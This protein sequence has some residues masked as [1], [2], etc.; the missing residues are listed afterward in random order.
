MN[1]KFQVNDLSRK[2]DLKRTFSKRDATNWSYKLNKITEFG[3][4]AI[5]SYRNDRLEE[6]YNESFLKKTELTIKENQ[7]VM[8]ALNLK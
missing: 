5:P 3:I 4:D 8:K 1:L 2:T 6:R 7:D